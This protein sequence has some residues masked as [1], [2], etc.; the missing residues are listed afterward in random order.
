MIL[1]YFFL[2]FPIVLLAVLNGT[3]RDFGYKP[4]AGDLTAHQ[5]STVTLI[6]LIAVYLRILRTRWKITSANQAWLIGL[7]WLG[8]TIAFEFGFGHYIAGNP[9]SKLLH[10]YNIAEGRVWCFILI[11][12]LIGPYISYRTTKTT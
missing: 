10:D 1:R 8:M 6:L 3:L 9:W 11:A 2:W 7:M 4:F 12:V 5:I